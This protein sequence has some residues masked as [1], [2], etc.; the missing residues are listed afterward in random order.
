MVGILHVSPSVVLESSNCQQIGRK[1]SITRFLLMKGQIEGLH[2]DEGKV[3]AREGGKQRCCAAASNSK[4]TSIAA[5][6]NSE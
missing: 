2:D 5:T 1:K 3:V 4:S 6:P